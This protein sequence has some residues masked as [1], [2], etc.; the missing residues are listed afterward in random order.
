MFAK[1]TSPTASVG[2]GL[3]PRGR[4]TGSDWSSRQS[5]HNRRSSMHAVGNGQAP[6]QRIRVER[7]IYRQRNGKYAVCFM[8]DGRARFRTVGYDLELAREQ[9]RAFMHSARFGIVAAAPRLRFG[10]V[11]AW[12]VERFERKVV[13]GE[14]HERTLRSTATT[15]KGTCS[16]SSDRG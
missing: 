7:G 6:K 16:R 4:K 9:R 1:E 2:R 8:L 10:A 14:R 15:S 12:W 5:T 3:S 11:A 13:S